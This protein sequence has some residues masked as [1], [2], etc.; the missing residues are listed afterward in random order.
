MTAE[1]ATRVAC[2]PQGTCPKP[3]V[4]IVNDVVLCDR[5]GGWKRYGSEKAAAKALRLAVKA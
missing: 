2:R 4:V 3:W 5:R 1:Q